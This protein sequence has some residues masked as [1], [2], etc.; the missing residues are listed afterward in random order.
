MRE[1][2]RVRIARAP[3]PWVRERCA[4]IATAKTSFK[5]FTSLQPVHDA[6]QPKTEASPLP[7]SHATKGNESY[8]LK[9]RWGTE[10]ASV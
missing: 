2:P 3:T 10:P 4:A 6:T 7:C 8:S 1:G 9:P 5:E